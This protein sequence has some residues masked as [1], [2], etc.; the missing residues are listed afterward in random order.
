MTFSIKKL[1]K[2]FII[3]LLVAPQ[4]VCADETKSKKCKTFQ[5]LNVCNSL[6]AGSVTVNGNAIVSGTLA[7]DGPVTAESF[8]TPS[9]TLSTGIQNYAVLINSFGVDS[10]NNILWEDTPA[11]NLSAGITLDN[12]TGFITLPVGLFLV[13]YTVRFNIVSPATDPTGF[14]QLQQGPASGP[15]SPIAQPAISSTSANIPDNA[16]LNIQLQPQVTGY[17]LV[18]V[19]SASDNTIALNILLFNGMR[20]LGA[21]GEENAELVIVQLK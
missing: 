7:V 2:V 14:A 15:L 6:K 5:N 18:P 21:M 10:G 8:S 19:T 9:G 16:T 12:T 13:Q 4:V 1:H 3:M 17:A 11:G 20:L